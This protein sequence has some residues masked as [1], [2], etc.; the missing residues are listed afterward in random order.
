MYS[1]VQ[2]WTEHSTFTKYQQYIW[3]RNLSREQHA[4]L[5]LYNVNGQ[6]KWAGQWARVIFSRHRVIREGATIY[7]ICPT[8]NVKTSTECD[9]GV[10]LFTL[11]YQYSWVHNFSMRYIY[12][13]HSNSKYFNLQFFMKRAQFQDKK[14]LNKNNA[15]LPNSVNTALNALFSPALCMYIQ[16]QQ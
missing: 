7:R 11:R 16:K 15:F 14:V 1:P 2:N 6:S 3:L 10:Q 4:S 12:S 5:E 9:E 13:Q 8:N